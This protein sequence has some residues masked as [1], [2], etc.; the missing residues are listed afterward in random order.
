[1]AKYEAWICVEGDGPDERVIYKGDDFDD[2]A[3]AMFEHSDEVD[4]NVNKYYLVNDTIFEYFEDF[5]DN[6]W[7]INPR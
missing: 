5:D 1:M 4:C 6:N 3:A 2:L 7:I